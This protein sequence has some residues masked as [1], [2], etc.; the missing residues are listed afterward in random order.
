MNLIS[1]RPIFAALRHFIG[2]PAYRVMLPKMPNSSKYSHLAS[3]RFAI[4]NELCPASSAVKQMDIVGN[5]DEKQ[6]SQVGL[7][8][9]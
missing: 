3:L 2:L 6:P 5:G 7:A 4:K 8:G 9:G 1:P